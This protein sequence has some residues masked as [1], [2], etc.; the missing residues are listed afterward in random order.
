MLKRFVELEEEIKND[1]EVQKLR[2][3]IEREMG[4]LSHEDLHHKVFSCVRA[5][6]D[7]YR[8]ATTLRG[9]KVI[10]ELNKIL[11]VEG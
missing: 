1:P 9:R 5:L 4:T 3:K 8:F 2:E 7:D 10:N 11:V 6:E